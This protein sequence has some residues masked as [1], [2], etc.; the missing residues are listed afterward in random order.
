MKKSPYALR[1]VLVDKRFGCASMTMARFVPWGLPLET[2]GIQLQTLAKYLGERP[3]RIRRLARRLGLACY[4]GNAVH[5]HRKRRLHGA[6]LMV[7]E[8]DAA[9]VIVYVRAKEGRKA[10]R[11]SRQKPQSP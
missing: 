4:Y 1:K 2:P 3:Q 10:M 9:R 11:S 6:R 7:S 8:D 5:E